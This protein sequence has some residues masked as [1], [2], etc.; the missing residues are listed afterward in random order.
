MLIMLPDTILVLQG[1]KNPESFQGHGGHPANYDI[2]P[3]HDFIDVKMILTY[4]L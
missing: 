4:T 3:N 2:Y 1:Q